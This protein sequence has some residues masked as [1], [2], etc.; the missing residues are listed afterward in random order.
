MP[1]TNPSS[2]TPEAVSASLAAATALFGAIGLALWRIET[3]VKMLTHAKDERQTTAA[4]VE[5][6]KA[7]TVSTDK[8]PLV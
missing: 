8:N 2:W 4:S 5:E 3:I 1:T 7:A 6:I